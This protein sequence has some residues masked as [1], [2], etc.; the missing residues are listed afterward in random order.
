MVNYIEIKISQ[1]SDKLNLFVKSVWNWTI[2]TEGS[3]LKEIKNSNHLHRRNVR[4]IVK[5]SFLN[6]Y[7]QQNR[8][9]KAF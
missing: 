2:T 4:I 6:T 5:A 1:F 3:S 7:L 9:L 8:K